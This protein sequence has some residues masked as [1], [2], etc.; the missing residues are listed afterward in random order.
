MWSIYLLV[1]LFNIA[2]GHGDHNHKHHKEDLPKKLRRGETV[3]KHK[4]IH[5]EYVK[6]FKLPEYE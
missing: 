1:V 4:C 3:Q 6:N 5:D 2:L